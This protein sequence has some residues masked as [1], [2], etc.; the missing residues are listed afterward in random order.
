[1]NK[2][3]HLSITFETSSPSTMLRA[4]DSLNAKTPIEGV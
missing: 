1:M 3:I 4:L 2:I